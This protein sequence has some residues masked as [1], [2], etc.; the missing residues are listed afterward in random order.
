MEG[1]GT[2]DEG[3]GRGAPFARLLI[4]NPPASEV[5]LAFIKD[6]APKGSGDAVC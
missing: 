6:D 3:K 1:G 5:L 4:T 2:V